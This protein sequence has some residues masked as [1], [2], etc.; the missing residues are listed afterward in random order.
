MNLRQLEAFRATIESGSITG[1]AELPHVSQ[2]SVSRLIADLERSFGF[3]LFLRAG[4]GLSATVE[5]RRFYSAVDSMFL[6]V[7]RLEELAET[8]RTTADDVVSVGVIP[9]LSQSLLPDAVA[10]IL[11]AKPSMQVML[12]TR[13]TPAITD[14]VRMQQFD[15]GIIGREP[16][17]DGV[18]ILHHITVPYV[19]LLPDAHSDADG[20]ETRLI[21]ENFAKRTVSSPLAASIPTR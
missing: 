19:C 13:N 3:P 15:F 9:S 12:S 10:D 5:A 18:E 7:N 14:A 4:R 11:K 8:I 6:G 2:P 20:D 16:L 1:A 21:C 17:Y